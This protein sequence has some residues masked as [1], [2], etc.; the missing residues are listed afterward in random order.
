MS[1]SE[2]SDDTGIG[3]NEI[4]WRRF[5][6]SQ[7]VPDKSTG[8]LTAPSIVFR[9]DEM[10]VHIASLTSLPLVLAEY[11]HHGI[12][13]ITAADARAEGL[14]VVRDPMPRD[15]S[16]AL[17]CRSDRNKITKTQAKSLKQRSQMVILPLV[18]P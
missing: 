17:V 7:M 2:R 10:S 3:D 14:I 5:H 18:V 6:P 4:L 8:K 11:P 15:A 12:I 13:S 1:P 16:H 9:D